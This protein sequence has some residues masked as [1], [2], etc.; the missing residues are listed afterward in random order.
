MK[1]VELLQVNNLEKKMKNIGFNLNQKKRN[2]MK[3]Y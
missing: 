1:K 3:N 2:E